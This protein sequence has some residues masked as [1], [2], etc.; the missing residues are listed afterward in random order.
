MARRPL[1]EEEKQVLRDRLAQARTMPRKPRAAEVPL[2]QRPEFK[3]AVAGAV[4]SVINELGL[5]RAAAGVTAPAAAGPQDFAWADVLSARLA[6]YMDQGPIA[7][8]EKRLPPEVIEQRKRANE[9]MAKLLVK[10]RAT[11]E[12]ALERNEPAAASRATP[13][14][15]LTGKI[16][17]QLDTG[18]TLLEPLTRN[19]DNR[20]VDSHVRWWV[21]PNMLME[22][23]NEPAK[24]I[25]AAFTEAIGHGA[26]DDG[27]LDNGAPCPPSGGMLETDHAVS[28]MGNVW[29]GAAAAAVNRHAN[30]DRTQKSS[31]NAVLI[32][33]DDSPIAH[34]DGG[35][36]Y[37]DKYVLG[38][39]APPVRQNG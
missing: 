14:Y 13:I 9:R 2:E 16:I 8:G 28:P 3:A 12:A 24:E 27:L 25:F 26:P 37:Q 30:R 39:I 7:G 36:P 29:S 32:D 31:F 15:R 35:P 19:K 21:A 5:A 20:V 34:N 4:A 23:A 33:P 6:E 22:P 18:E 38:S 11:Y 1:S 17:A 10:W